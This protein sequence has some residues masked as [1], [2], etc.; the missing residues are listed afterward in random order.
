LI[1]SSGSSQDVVGGSSLVKES[2]VVVNGSWPIVV[3]VAFI[4][5][6][7]AFTVNLALAKGQKGSRG[8]S[9]GAVGV[10]PSVGDPVADGDRPDFTGVSCPLIIGESPKVVGGS[11]LV[12]VKACPIVIVGAFAVYPTLVEG[13]KGTRGDTGVDVGVHPSPEDIVPG[14]DNLVLAG[15]SSADAGDCLDLVEGTI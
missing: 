11:W 9:G 14:E 13:H 3:A 4:V 10:H 15:V 12:F 7:N 8:A 1:C 6:I 2:P 5:I